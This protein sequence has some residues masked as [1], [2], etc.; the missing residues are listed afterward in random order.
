MVIFCF[1]FCRVA[2]TRLLNFSKLE[3]GENRNGQKNWVTIF[4]FNTD[5]I[6][7]D[8]STYCAMQS[9]VCENWMNEKQVAGY[10]GLFFTYIHSLH[11]FKKRC[12]N[13]VAMLNYGSGLCG[14]IVSRRYHFP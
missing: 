5:A 11:S 6:L 1:R 4:Y 8:L 3:L 14:G 13:N 12:T 9:W 7:P 10:V 2:K